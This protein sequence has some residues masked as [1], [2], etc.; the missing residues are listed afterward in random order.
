MDVLNKPEEQ[1]QTCLDSALA[2]KGGTE[3]IWKPM[4]EFKEI[5]L[6][7]SISDCNFFHFVILLHGQRNLSILRSEDNRILTDITCLVF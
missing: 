4:Y 6:E 2:E 3:S 5:C 7:A 1:N